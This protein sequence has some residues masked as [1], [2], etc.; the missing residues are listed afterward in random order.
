MTTTPLPL[1]SAELVAHPRDAKKYVFG[2]AVTYE[3]GLP[4]IFG[5]TPPLPGLYT[6]Y[7]DVTELVTA[8]DDKFAVFTVGD[9]LQ[10]NFAVPSGPE[11]VN[12]QFV[13]RAVNYYHVRGNPQ[14][15]DTLEPYPY[16]AM[17]AWP[18]TAAQGAYPSDEEHATYK[19]TYNTR[20][21]ADPN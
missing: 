8:K 11:P 13:I 4:A 2:N 3:Y 12:R 14:M 6:R 18:Y 9:E 17:P 20:V 16:A 1:T 5:A 10:L 15:A 19:A 21:V 7:G